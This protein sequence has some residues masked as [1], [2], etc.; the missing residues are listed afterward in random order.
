MPTTPAASPTSS[1]SSTFSA[2]SSSTSNS[3]LN[4]MYDIVYSQSV[5]HAQKPAEQPRGNTNN[6]PATLA[7]CMHLARYKNQL[8]AGATAADASEDGRRDNPVATRGTDT[9]FVENLRTLVRYSLAWEEGQKACVGKGVKHGHGRNGHA[10]GGGEVKAAGASVKKRRRLD[11]LPL[12]QCTTCHTPLGR[13]HVCLHCVFMGCWADGHMAHHMME[14]GHGFAMDFSHR[15]L[16]CVECKDYVYDLEI[17]DRIVRLETLRIDVGGG[18]RIGPVTLRANGKS[19]PK[20]PRY[21]V[22]HPSDDEIQLITQKSKLTPCQGIRGLFNMGNTCFMNVILQ[23]LIHNPLLRAYFLSDRHNSNLCITKNCMCC[24]MDKLFAKPYGPTSFL[25]AMW[26]S[27]KELAGY[28]QQ[29]AHEFFISALN[30]IHEGCSGTK[31]HSCTCIVHQT[32]AGLLQSDVTCLKCYNVTTAYDPMFDISLDLRPVERKKRQQSLQQLPIVTPK[33]DGTETASAATAENGANATEALASGMVAGAAKEQEAIGAAKENGSTV[34]GVEVAGAGAGA[35]AGTGPATVAEGVAV[36]VVPKKLKEGNSL[37]DCLDRYTHPEKLGPKEYS[38]GKCG[39]TFQEATKQ[40]SVK[41]LPPVMSFQ[42]KRF[43]HGVSATKIDTKIKFPVEL[44]M[45]PYT[46]SAKRTTLAKAA[47]T[48]AADGAA[49]CNGRD[50]KTT[51]SASSSNSPYV[52]TLFAVVNH[53]GKMDTGHY[54]MYAKHR[55]EWFKF[56]DHNV[57]MAHQRDVLDSKA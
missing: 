30:Q 54:T 29:D 53:Q 14:K 13:L 22:W 33:I 39:N 50:A 8:K 44:D 35:G 16:Y 4:T 21:T 5:D 36:G 11:E 20:R 40:L 1:F 56:D 26:L 38:C 41:K 25:Q 18:Y 27:S 6:V 46:T 52:Y 31:S 57:T 28:A 34:G 19:L 9:Q 45:S 23:S 15:N 2:A 7:G 43:E 10:V 3:S 32:F 48:G 47:A 49:G 24:E 55:G 17:L 51:A 42:L 12:P 37:V